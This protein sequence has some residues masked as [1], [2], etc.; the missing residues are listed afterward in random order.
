MFSID[1]SDAHT[2]YFF[3]SF[4]T[5]TVLLKSDNIDF[6]QREGRRFRRVCAVSENFYSLLSF[7]SFS[8]SQAATVFLFSLLFLLLW[9]HSRVVLSFF[10]STIRHPVVWGRII[11]CT[12]FICFSVAIASGSRFQNCFLRFFLFIPGGRHLSFC[13][14]QFFLAFIFLLPQP[15]ALDLDCFLI[16][17]IFTGVFIN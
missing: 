6:F 15:V 10:L 1:W 2:K 16:C 8:S 9:L 3:L 4:T 7:S 12:L 11:R 17:R 14:F 5:Q 13:C